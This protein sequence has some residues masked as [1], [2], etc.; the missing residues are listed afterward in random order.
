MNRN[1]KF[2]LL[3]FGIIF[4]NL[5]Q[6]K[7]SGLR[8]FTYDSAFAAGSETVTGI[9]AETSGNA[10]PLEIS[11]MTFNVENL[12]D[13][14]D[15]EGKDDE[16]YLPLEEKKK[17]AIKE[18]CQRIKSKF[19][20]KQ[21][22]T[23][24]W[25]DKVLQ[26]KLKNVAQTI[27][28]VENGRGPDHLIL[29]EVENK[30]ILSIL[31]KN[32]LKKANY[33]TEVLIEGRDPRGIDVAFL[34][35]FPLSDQ[36]RLHEIRFQAKSAKDRER[37]ENTRGILEVEV[38]ISKQE[39]IKFMA[40][41]F[42]SQGNPAYFREQAMEFLSE[43]VRKNKKHKLIVGGDFNITHREDSKK[44][45]FKKYLSPWG[46]ISH[47]DACES[48]LGTHWFKGKWSFLDVIFFN[49]ELLSQ[50]WE[51]VDEKVEVV[52][53]NSQHYVDNKPARFDEEKLSGVSDHLPVYARLKWK[54]NNK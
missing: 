43:L 13:N 12:F 27:L 40:L 48:C 9:S 37:I 4:C 20:K 42:P 45:Y 29:N 53:K 23:L 47:L 34:S 30:N 26:A 39:K 22:F 16:S 46:K 18:K 52:T 36:P 33:T 21:C 38:K 7:T 24:D 14:Q 51:L 54:N 6:V 31:N 44:E 2:T 5:L 32:Y 19:Y 49:N 41:H 11:V 8:I 10:N 35:R 17:P 15:D 25:N 50:S 1:I 28:S 3:L